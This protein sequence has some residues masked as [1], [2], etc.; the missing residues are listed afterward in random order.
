MFLKSVPIFILL[1]QN[2][3]QL[4]VDSKIFIDGEFKPSAQ[5]YKGGEGIPK[6]IFSAAVKFTPSFHQQIPYR[7][8][9]YGRSDWKSFCIG[10]VTIY[11]R[12]GVYPKRGV[13]RGPDHFRF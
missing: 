12:H 4:P 13:C 10:D 1:I 3:E 7:P 6:L 2:I 9:R 11:H 8:E 5:P